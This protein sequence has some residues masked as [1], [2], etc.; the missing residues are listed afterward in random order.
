MTKRKRQRA[1]VSH[2]RNG[3]NSSVSKANIYGRSSMLSSMYRRLLG[4]QSRMRTDSGRT[5]GIVGKQ[6]N[7]SLATLRLA[8]I[9]DIETEVKAAAVTAGA[10]ASS[11]VKLYLGWVKDR[12]HY[13]NQSNSLT[14]LTL[15]DVV[16]R[17]NPPSTVVDEPVETWNLGITD[18][19]GTDSLELGETPFKSPYF[20]R[21][22]S[23]AKVTVVDLE[24]GQQHEHIRFHRINRVVS[25]V[26]WDRLTT[27][28][29][30]WLTS[31]TMAVFH[32]SLI[33]ESA[34]PNTVTYH[35][36]VIDWARSVEV[37][38]G[39]IPFNTMRVQAPVGFPSAIVDA[40]FMGED[41]DIDANVINA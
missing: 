14:K 26:E 31:Y 7:F 21:Y 19:G 28:T 24:P 36:S 12:L 27:T 9:T 2:I 15:Y 11:T 22:F 25:S 41:Q 16:C 40:D 30:P 10:S 17:R 20:K 13:R 5:T 1:G 37:R 18:Q 34:T 35:S 39:Y 4:I 33:H 6:Q 29:V 3:D 32:G 23:V 38:Y 8:D